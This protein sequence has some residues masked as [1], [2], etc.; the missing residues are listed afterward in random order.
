M[1]IIVAPDPE[2]ASRHA[3]SLIRRAI[4]QKPNASLLLPTGSTPEILYKLLTDKVAGGYLTFA[5][6]QTYNLDE[7]LDLPQQHAQSYYTFMW[8]HLFDK[9]DIK[10]SNVHIPSS[11]PKNHQAYCQK[12][13]K[14]IQKAGI[15]LAVLGL[16][17]NGHIGFNEP[18]TSF[19]ST[20]HIA[21]LTTSTTKAN[22]RFFSSSAEVPHQA[23]TVGLATIMRAKK[24]ILLAFGANKAGVIQKAFE[25]PPTTE[26]PASI[27]QNHK[28][29]TV[30]LDQE[31][32]AR[33]RKTKLYPPVLSGIKLYSRFNLP[34]GK[35]IVFFSPHP[36]DAS[37]CSG[38]LLK[39]LSK[40][41]KVYEI[42]ATTGH[43]A[44]NHGRGKQ[45]RIK[46]RE[47]EARQEAKILGTKPIFLRS[48]FYDNGDELPETDMKKA[49]DLMKKINPDIAFVPNKSDPH[50]THAMTR[51][52]ALAALP[53][54]ISLWSFESPWG[55]FGHHRF[56]AVFEFSN[57]LMSAKLAAIRAHASQTERTPFDEAAHSIAHF[58]RITIAEQLF[59]ELGQ[60]PLATQPH[61]ELYQ[62]TKW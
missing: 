14:K 30:I 38:A 55:P 13:E 37:I 22:A 44:A 47:T 41:N 26:V 45:Q 24:I 21:N 1:P 10:K 28:D 15:D 42:I 7:Y 32:A 27:L 39:S 25:E 56:N 48:K 57:S 16:G 53:H 35:K 3:A 46:L 60:E 43:R 6:A 17:Q 52:L 33:L 50:P 59:S 5:H 40:N 4:A 29:I 34:R 8:K 31:S 54:D 20:T 9:I 49:R 12:Y 11:Q 51:K 23:I 62:I 2:I 61:L 18:G 58:R 36:D 19:D